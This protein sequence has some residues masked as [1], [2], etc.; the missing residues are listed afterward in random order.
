MKHSMFLILAALIYVG[1]TGSKDT[2]S[3]PGSG[4]TVKATPTPTSTATTVDPTATPI[5]SSQP[6]P[7]T[8]PVLS[9]GS[10]EPTDSKVEELYKLNFQKLRVEKYKG[11]Y[12]ISG[13]V[14]EEN[15]QN[16]FSTLNDVY[17]F[18]YVDNYVEG[19]VRGNNADSSIITRCLRRDC[20]QFFV[21][22]L[23]TVYD[24]NKT[25]FHAQ[26]G[27]IF[28]VDWN[29]SFDHDNPQMLS[30]KIIQNEYL[31]SSDLEEMLINENL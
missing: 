27:F 28:A 21:N 20:S 9:Q 29:R 6:V 16:Y 31:N 19:S 12:R 10:P 1:C 25:S 23:L 4:Y 22:W 2:A 7:T 14:I 13:Y 5:D 24:N 3:L 30:F 17:R 26:I 8:T 15:K 11:A 18:P